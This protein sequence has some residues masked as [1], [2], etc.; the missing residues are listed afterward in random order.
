MADIWARRD[1]DLQ[2]DGDKRVCLSMRE[3]GNR[4]FVHSC[5]NETH[6]VD[7]LVATGADSLEL[8]PLTCKK[9]I[10][11]KTCVLGML[12]VAHILWRGKP[13]A[14]RRHTIDIMNVMAPG[15]DFILGPGCALPPDV[16]VDN[17]HVIM[18][19]AKSLGR[20]APDGSL[21]VPPASS[22]Q[23]K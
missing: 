17:I 18:K 20:Y 14:V 22:A 4:S 19:C 11:G 6:L 1:H 3:V 16:P 9:A 8:D 12:D 10:H 15:G 5:G 7:N 21:P 23:S 2:Y 13:E